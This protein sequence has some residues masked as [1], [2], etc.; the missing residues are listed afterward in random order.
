LCHPNNGKKPIIEPD[1]QQRLM[2]PGDEREINEKYREIC[3]K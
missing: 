3:E 2:M 1:I